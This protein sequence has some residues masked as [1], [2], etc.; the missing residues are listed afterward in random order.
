[1]SACASPYLLVRTTKKSSK[2]IFMPADQHRS[3]VNLRPKW[4]LWADWHH[5]R[6]AGHLSQPPCRPKEAQRWRNRWHCSRERGRSNLA[7][8]PCSSI[9][10]AAQTTSPQPCTTWQRTASRP[11]CKAT[12]FQ[13]ILYLPQKPS[14][15]ASFLSNLSTCT[16][17]QQACSHVCSYQQEC[18][19][20]HSP[21][22]LSCLQS[23]DLLV[24]FMHLCCP[25][26]HAWHVC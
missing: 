21:N 4:S 19:S 23:S 22:C 24:A 20:T 26:F 8:H 13:A 6:Q 17:G 9:H 10:L 7:N 25:S 1:M 18:Q 11:C 14:S 5:Q 3:P 2:L 12:K 16:A 15:A